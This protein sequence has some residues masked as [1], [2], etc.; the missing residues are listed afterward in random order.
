VVRHVKLRALSGA[1][2][3]SGAFQRPDKF[4]AYVWQDKELRS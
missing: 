2:V 4:V 3:S 1:Q